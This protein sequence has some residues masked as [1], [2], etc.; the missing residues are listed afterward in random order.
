MKPDPLAGKREAINAGNLD[1]LLWPDSEEPPVQVGELFKLRMCWVEITRVHRV[2]PMDSDWQWRAEFTRHFPADRPYLLGPRGYVR[3][4]K[5]AVSAQDD[6][7]PGTLDK[8]N[9]EDRSEEHRAAGEPPEPEAVSPHEVGSTTGDLVAR[10]RYEHEMESR[11]LELE[12]MPLE[13]RL[14]RILALAE[15]GVN[16][17]RE[18]KAIRGKVA[19]AERKA[20]VRRAA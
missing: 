2:Q 3:E 10:R 20:G 12:A 17:K 7:N 18:L 9:P 13:R 5:S 15:S 11:R 19:E 14:S 4:P 1:R 16:V 6:P 8:V